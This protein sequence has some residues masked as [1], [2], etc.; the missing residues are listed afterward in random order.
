M[1]KRTTRRRSTI[2]R[3]PLAEAV[4]PTAEV[5]AEET[6]P[7]PEP[8]TG[9]LP[10]PET[11]ADAA[12]AAPVGLSAAVVE[13]APP[14]AE[15]A[16]V[17]QPVPRQAS[18]DRNAERGRRAIG[19]RLELLSGYGGRKTTWIGLSAVGGEQR[20]G[21]FT[22]SDEFIPLEGTIRSIESWT[23]GKEHRVVAAIG[24]GW[25]F[26]TLMGTLGGVAAAVVRLLHPKRM[27]FEIKLKDGRA[28]AGRTDS[29]TIGA[30]RELLAASASPD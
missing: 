9:P 27:I 21:F 10:A 17:S 6:L 18:S 29:I 14:A 7:P 19:G 3:D 24:W 13:A 20:L 22:A 4:P 30:L 25:T 28:F 15:A 23:D 16:P 1:A 12:L 8:V 26:A 5:T 11:A 2:G